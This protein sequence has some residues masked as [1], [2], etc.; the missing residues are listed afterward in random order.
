MTRINCIP[1]KE[2]TDKHLLAEYRELPRIFRLVKQA[3]NKGFSPD[4]ISIPNQYT[5][6]TGH[7][8]FFYDK[9]TFLWK[10]QCDIINECL[11][12]GFKIKY[13]WFDTIS[14]IQSFE[15]NKHW[16]N[17]WTPTEEA[18]QINRERIAER[19]K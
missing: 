1:V 12:R 7:C 2:L 8:K 4:D 10:R 19:L 13:D 5:L 15:F 16:I 6:G 11:F 3:Q 18:M 9:V 14:Y 17:D